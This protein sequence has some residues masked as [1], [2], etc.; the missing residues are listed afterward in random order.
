MMPGTEQTYRHCVRCGSA[1]EPGTALCEAHTEQTENARAKAGDRV[2]TEMVGKT[3]HGRCVGRKEDRPVVL[4]DGA[5]RA[6]PLEDWCLEVIAR[7]DE[8]CA[9]TA[10]HPE[11][12]ACDECRPELF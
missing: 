5:E 7:P 11:G 10:V 1:A 6:Y 2:T 9:G 3:W 8:P 4:W 12:S